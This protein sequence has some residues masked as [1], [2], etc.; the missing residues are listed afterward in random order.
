MENLVE[1]LLCTSHSSESQNQDFDLTVNRRESTLKQKFKIT[2]KLVPRDRT[3]YHCCAC[4]D[5]EKSCYILRM[6]HSNAGKAQLFL[7]SP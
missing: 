1:N 4:K 3:Q 7:G 5:V 2:V 6:L